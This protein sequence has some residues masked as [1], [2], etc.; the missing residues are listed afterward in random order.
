MYLLYLI[1]NLC[2]SLFQSLPM[3][4]SNKKISPI[5]ETLSK[6]HSE[7]GF[8]KVDVDVNAESAADFK[9]RFL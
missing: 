8:G 2:I 3:L 9:V 1:R 6:T 4:L 7:V 5:Y